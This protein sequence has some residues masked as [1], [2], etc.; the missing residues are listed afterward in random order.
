MFE[1]TCGGEVSVPDM[2]DHLGPTTP[3]TATARTVC[4]ERRRQWF[5][6]SAGLIQERREIQ[7]MSRMP[8]LTFFPGVLPACGAV[9]KGVPYTGWQSRWRK[10]RAELWELEVVREERAVWGKTS[11]NT[12]RPPGKAVVENSTTHEARQI[13]TPELLGEKFPELMQV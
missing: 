3:P 2:L 4:G 5:L 8:A 12:R 13:A 11:G 1:N 9:G 6:A 10:Y 7:E